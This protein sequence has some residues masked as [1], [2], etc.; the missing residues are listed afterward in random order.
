MSVTSVLIE[1][2][3][4]KSVVK[5]RKSNNKQC[6][7][8]KQECLDLILMLAFVKNVFTQVYY[9]AGHVTLVA[10]RLNFARDSQTT[11]NLQ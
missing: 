10:M 2:E 6:L 7:V 5:L 4:N 1:F 8:I 9:R 3:R 11:L